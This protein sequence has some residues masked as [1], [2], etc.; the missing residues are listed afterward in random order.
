MKWWSRV[1][2]FS[3]ST[4]LEEKVLSSGCL[5][6]SWFRTKQ[7]CFPGFYK[8]SSNL[9]H[10][11]FQFIKISS[12]I[13]LLGCCNIVCISICIPHKIYEPLKIKMF[14]KR[15]INSTLTHE[16]LI[17]VRFSVVFGKNS[18]LSVL[19]GLGACSF[20]KKGIISEL[21]RVFWVFSWKLVC[22]QI[23]WN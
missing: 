10:R 3:L 17:Q 1:Q 9:Y 7:S 20:Y 18:S 22:I 13:L 6:H 12:I 11:C 19:S 5:Q 21:Q 14:V 16:P 2:L 8:Y 23:N 15:A 4:E